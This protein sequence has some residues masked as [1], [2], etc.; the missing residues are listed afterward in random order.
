MSSWVHS[1]A[2]STFTSPPCQMLLIQIAPRG[3]TYPQVNSSDIIIHRVTS[4]ERRVNV[5]DRRRHQ[6]ATF[7][8]YSSKIKTH[9]LTGNSTNMELRGGGATGGM[10]GGGVA[11]GKRHIH[12]LKVSREG[13]CL[14]FWKF[15]KNKHDITFCPL[16]LTLLSALTSCRPCGPDFCV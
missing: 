4:S 3:H 1:T 6:R 12:S 15:F 8:L 16:K 7:K 10:W 14:T 13:R 2:T 5:I 11:E 9:F